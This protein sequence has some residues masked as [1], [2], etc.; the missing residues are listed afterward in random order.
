MFTGIIE[1]M[2][3]LRSMENEGDNI[4]YILHSDMAGAFKVDQ[5][6]AHNGCCLTIVELW[7]EQNLYKVTAIKETLIKTNLRNWKAGD[8]INIERS[9]SFN[10]RLD[11]HIVQ[12]H[13]DVTGYVPPLKTNQEVG[14]IVF[15]TTRRT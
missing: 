15:N 2:A 7:P 11:G 12:G 4:H 6:I 8:Q 3:T 13:V 10:G 9:L 14:S 1:Q 5:S